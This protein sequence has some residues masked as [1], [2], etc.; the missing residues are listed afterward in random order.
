MS[1]PTLTERG[2][3]FCK[4]AETFLTLANGEL[5]DRTVTEAVDAFT[6][7]EFTYAGRDV[8]PAGLREQ[9]ERIERERYD[10]ALR[11]LGRQLDADERALERLLT[12]TF[13][14]AA[15]CPPDPGL[16][17]KSDAVRLTAEL[18]RNSR[19]DAAIRRLTGKTL[20]FVQRLH[21]ATP[22][23][24]NAELVQI[25]EAEAAAGFSEIQLTAT[26]GDAAALMALKRQIRERQQARIAARAPEALAVQAQLAKT[27]SAT[28]D[29]MRRH[30][31][32]RGV[33]QRPKRRTVRV[34]LAHV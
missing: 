11:A 19:Q 25:I 28:L 3:Q 10:E 33:A 30:V 15:E 23:A 26:E 34:P 13:T 20:Q 1:E 29:V 32:S 31:R 8:T 24:E 16:E 14:A 7:K 21:A 5:A 9:V 27:R 12:A 4:A 17:A 6:G 18:V 2:A 22:D